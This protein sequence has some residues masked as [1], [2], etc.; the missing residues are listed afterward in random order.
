[1]QD[2]EKILYIIFVIILFIIIVILIAWNVSVSL[3]KVDPKTC[4]VLKG[5][6][7]IMTDKS[8]KLKSVCGTDAQSLC[9]YSNVSN[10]SSAI[11]RCNA[12]FEI[13]ETFT[14]DANTQVMNIVELSGEGMETVYVRQVTFNM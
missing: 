11:D 12:F 2:G 4:P 10:L 3:G 7:A 6:F 5:E 9:T 8:V 1:M 13:C 14:Y